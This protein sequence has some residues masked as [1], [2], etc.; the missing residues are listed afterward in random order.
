[1][2]DEPTDSTCGSTVS[3]Q[4]A[5]GYVDVTD[6]TLLTCQD[7]GLWETPTGCERIGMKLLAFH[8]IFEAFCYLEIS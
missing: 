1:M 8:E 3:V 6:K 7:N 5:D 2:I 4:C